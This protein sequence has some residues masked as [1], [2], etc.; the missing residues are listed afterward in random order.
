MQ[1]Q[2]LRDQLKR[3]NLCLMQLDECVCKIL[4]GNGKKIEYKEIEKLDIGLKFREMY[5]NKFYKEMLSP[6]KSKRK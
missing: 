4:F 2:I 1:S 3:V 6:A 5:I